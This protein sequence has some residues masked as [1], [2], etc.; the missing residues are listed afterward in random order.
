MSL[1]TAH[2]VTF[3]SPG[4][5]M[6]EDTTKPIESWDVD[7]A[8]KM[9]AQIVERHG[10][11]PYA[12]YFTTRERTDADLDSRQAARSDLYYL[13]PSKFTSERRDLLQIVTDRGVPAP[14][15]RAEVGDVGAVD[16]LIS[17]NTSVGG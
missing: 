17:G 13:G 2:F 11:R 16:D 7:E 3:L 10:A 1:K 6:A 8:V 4:T 5:L 12:F 14:I 15:V 9:A